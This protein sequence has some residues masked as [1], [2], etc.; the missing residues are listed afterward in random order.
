MQERGRWNRRNV[1]RM[2]FGKRE[3]R[4]KIFGLHYFINS[5]GPEI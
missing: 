5:G 2:R 3:S 4:K 1:G